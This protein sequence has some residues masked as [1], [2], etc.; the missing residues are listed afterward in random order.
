MASEE[1][2]ECYRQA[3]AAVGEGFCPGHEAALG[4]DGWC[5]PCGGRWFLDGDQ[6]VFR[7]RGL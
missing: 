4:A 5:G 1:Y 6:A 2:L 7:S 3:A